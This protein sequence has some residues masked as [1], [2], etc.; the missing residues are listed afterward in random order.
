MA[1]RS[2]C[3][4]GTPP[5]RNVFERSPRLITEARWCVY[6]LI[7]LKSMFQ[8]ILLVYDI[9]NEKSFENIR[10]WI[11]NIE[12][13]SASDVDRMIVGNKCDMEDRRMVPKER[14]HQVGEFL[15]SI[16]LT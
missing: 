10:N 12:E 4:S 13:H 5:V 11:R 1:R 8:G 14:G 9:T 3:K 6:C 15:Y 16:L 7:I 2:N